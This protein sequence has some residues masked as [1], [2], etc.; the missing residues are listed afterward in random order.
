MNISISIDCNSQA[1]LQDALTGA[2]NQ[3]ASTASNI[4]NE[5]TKILVAIEEAVAAGLSDLVV[6][7]TALYDEIISIYEDLLDKLNQFLGLISPFPLSVDE[8]P[9]PNITQLNTS[10]VARGKAIV[11]EY[12]TF[13]IQKILGLIAELIPISLLV[14]LPFLGNVDIVRFYNDAAYRSELKQQI[15]D[16]LEAVLTVLPSPI[17]EIYTGVQGGL[18]SI[19][20]QV[21]EIWQWFVQQ[22]STGG[23][24]LVHI[25]I[26]A[27]ISEFQ[28]IWDDLGLPDIVALLTLDIEALLETAIS[29]ATDV[30][31]QVISVA[32]STYESVNQLFNAGEATE[33]ELES[34]MDN[35][36]T[37]VSGKWA[38]IVEYVLDIE[39]FG[40]AVRD[41]VTLY[42]GA[43]TVTT[44]GILNDIISQ[45]KDWVIKFPLKLLLEWMDVV[46]EFFE[47]IGLSALVDIITMTLCDFLE[48]IGFP[49]SIE[50]AIPDLPHLPVP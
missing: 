30:A 3:L 7:L 32:N 36:A 26:E 12:S 37:A 19:E 41:M 5:S 39:V 44:E 9:Y 21:Q 34:A 31:D 48:L 6:E 33:A 1:P 23:Y 27:L 11:T 25:A 35:L 40:I 18:Q 2:F 17:K 38:L 20:M 49:L 47:A 43:S 16:D 4:Y 45:A 42:D 28:D 24:G 50:I 22:L 14:P 13:L 10:W 29:L 46:K 15:A 8:I